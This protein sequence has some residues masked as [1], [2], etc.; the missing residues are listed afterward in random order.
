VHRYRVVGLVITVVIAAG[1][2]LFAVNPA[3]AQGSGAPD[4][5]IFVPKPRGSEDSLDPNAAVAQPGAVVLGRSGDRLTGTVNRIA[6]GVLLFSGPFLDREVGIFT[7][8]IRDIQFPARG[9]VENG[10]DLIVLTNDDRIFGKVQGMTSTDVAFDS[11]SVGFLKI[12]SRQI[13]EMRFQGGVGGLA[14]TDFAGGHATPLLITGGGW[15][16]GGG[17][18]RLSPPAQATLALEQSGAVTV[19]MDFA[20]MGRLWSLSLFADQPGKEDGESS[21]SQV[22][23][24]PNGILGARGHA[25]TL[26]LAQNGYSITAWKGASQRSTVISGLPARPGEAQEVRIAYDPATTEVKLWINGQVLNETKAPGAPKLGKYIVFSAQDSCDLK[27]LAAFDGIAVPG[28]AGKDADPNHETIVY[29]GGE[30]MRAETIALADGVFSVQTTFSEKPLSVPAGKVTAIL[31]SQAGRET[32][33]PPE[34]PVQIGLPKSLITV[35]LV[36]LTAKTATAKS[37]YLGD[38]RIAR[39]A[40]QSLRFLEPASSK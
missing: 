31:M 39:D 7:T 9:G 18:L 35:E 38:I 37:P 19:V 13:K 15:Q 8:A 36:E 11:A 40:I 16:V 14:H 34:H 4:S 23:L 12:N 32:P 21:P 28:T 20:R 27:S 22:N 25:L 29:Q 24:R 5:G 26:A 30:R 2:S 3:S 1:C 33:P 6:N 17:V 10:P